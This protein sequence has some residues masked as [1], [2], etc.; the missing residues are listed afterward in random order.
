MLKIQNKWA[1]IGLNTSQVMVRMQISHPRLK[2]MQEL[3]KVEMELTQARVSLDSSRCREEIGLKDSLAFIRDN[4]QKGHEACLSYIRETAERGD[5]MAR[6][7]KYQLGLILK[8]YAGKAFKKQEF[9][10]TRIP[11]SLVDVTVL[12]AR[13]E[14]AWQTGRV[15]YEYYPGEVTANTMGGRVEV[16]LR[17]QAG[18]ELSYEPQ[19]D[20]YG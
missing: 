1:Q 20:L 15:Q 16:Y 5:K 2:V 3:P 7:D 10:V 11:Q 6:P 18:I 14:T 12:P 17:Q 13:T 9:N 4:A 8:E 19:V